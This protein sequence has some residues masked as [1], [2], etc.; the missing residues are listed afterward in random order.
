[1]DQAREADG[2]SSR[3]GTDLVL[4]ASERDDHARKRAEHVI[5]RLGRLFVWVVG[6]IVCKSKIGAGGR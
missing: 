2:L 6:L 3:A 5:E 1:M 4:D